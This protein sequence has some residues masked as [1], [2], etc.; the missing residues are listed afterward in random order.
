MLDAAK[1]GAVVAVW[2]PAGDP[3]SGTRSCV[4]KALKR[5]LPI[6]WIN[7]AAEPSQR[8]ARLARPETLRRLLAA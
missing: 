2:D 8:R 4:L 3:R 1:D 7:P 6:I 5:G